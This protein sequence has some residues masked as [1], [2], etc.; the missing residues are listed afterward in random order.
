MTPKGRSQS[1]HTNFKIS[2]KLADI[3]RS[4]SG[5][6]NARGAANDEAVDGDIAEQPVD[7][8]CYGALVQG[9]TAQQR[10]KTVMVKRK[11]VKVINTLNPSQ[12]SASGFTRK[13]KLPRQK[14]RSAYQ[15]AISFSNQL[16]ADNS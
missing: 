12:D 1:R 15:S 5:S 10:Y 14:V 2:D 9:G 13:T 3:D 4:R 8:Q 16:N 11:Y 6:A 7:G